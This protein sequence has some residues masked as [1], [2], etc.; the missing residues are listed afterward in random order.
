M[1]FHPHQHQ[2][3]RFQKHSTVSR[4][5]WCMTYHCHISHKKFQ[6]FKLL[7]QMLVQQPCKLNELTCKINDCSSSKQFL[8]LQVYSSFRIY[9]TLYGLEFQLWE[10]C[11]CKY[12]PGLAN[13]FFLGE[14][15]HQSRKPCAPTLF[16]VPQ[17]SNSTQQILRLD[18]Q[19]IKYFC[20]TTIHF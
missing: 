1:Y 11:Y 12:V 19:T 15:T 4:E 10:N 3:T 20:Q 18:P 7:L 8:A 17:V 13:E 5:L 6:L 2:G 14:Q 16:Y 9:Y